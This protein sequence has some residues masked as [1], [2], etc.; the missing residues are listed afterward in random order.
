MYVC[1]QLLTY[2][3]TYIYVNEWIFKLFIM[4]CK[5][6]EAPSQIVVENN[7]SI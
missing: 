2:K 7:A 6:I 1:M 4:I 3:Y 5:F